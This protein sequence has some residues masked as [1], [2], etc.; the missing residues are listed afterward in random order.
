MTINLKT[1]LSKIRLPIVYRD[2]NTIVYTAP[3]NVR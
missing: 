2:A 3:Y 1:Y